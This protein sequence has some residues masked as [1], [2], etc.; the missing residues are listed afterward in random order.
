[1]VDPDLLAARSSPPVEA[2]HDEVSTWAGSL[3]EWPSAEGDR[4]DLLRSRPG[5]NER[6]TAA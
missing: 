5:R 1:M 3:A 2:T 6:S 4:K